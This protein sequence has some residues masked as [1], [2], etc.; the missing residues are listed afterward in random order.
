MKQSQRRARAPGWAWL[1]LFLP[2]LASEVDAGYRL[3]PPSGEQIRIFVGASRVIDFDRPVVR[4][5][6]G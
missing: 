6:I 1:F 2:I 4:V 3:P 5:S